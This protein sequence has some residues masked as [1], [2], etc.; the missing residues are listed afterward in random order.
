[1]CQNF[2]SCKCELKKHYDVVITASQGNQ[3]HAVVQNGIPHTIKVNLFQ[4]NKLSDQWINIYSIKSLIKW[5]FTEGRVKKH[6]HPV[7]TTQLHNPEDLDL[8]PNHCPLSIVVWGRETLQLWFWGKADYWFGTQ[9]SVVLACLSSSRG[10]HPQDGGSKVL[11]K[12]GILLQQ[13]TMSQL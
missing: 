4:H 10:L 8:T 6:L 11:Q 1:V 3:N 13:H 5:V 2:C 12:V 9:D 7:N